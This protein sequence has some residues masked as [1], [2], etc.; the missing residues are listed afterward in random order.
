VAPK[1]NIIACC[2]SGGRKLSIDS[3]IEAEATK[4]PQRRPSL[5]INALS[6]W[7][8]LGVNIVIGFLLTPF[9]I[10]HL[11]KTGYGIWTLVG[12]FIGYYGLL[13]LGVGSAITRYVARYAGQGD[14][15]ALNE[16]ASTAMAM[17]SCTGLLAI[18]ASFLLA[19][20]LAKFFQVAPEHLNGFRYTVWIIGLATGLSFPGNVF[21]SIVRAHERFVA[22]NFA[23][24]AI[25][26]VRAGLVTCLLLSGADLVGVA[27]ATLGSQ[28][29][30]LAVNFLLCRHFTPWVRVRLAFARS[31]FLRKLIAFGG[32][33]TV[34]VV[35]DIMRINLDRC[36]I[37]KMVG[38][39][40]VGVYG[41]AALIIRYM[42]Q[43]IATGMG[44]LTP[45][46]AALDGA[47][48]HAKLQGL[49][50][51]SLSVSALLAF[52][53]SM[54]AIIFGGRFITWWVG[55][56][57]AGAI[58]VLWI[59]ATAYAFALSQNPAIGLMYALK[60]HHYYAIATVIEAVA[61]VVLSILLA[62]KYGIIGV[63][64]GTM[65]PMLIVK[66]LVMPVYV[67][68]IAGIAIWQ[69]VKRIIVPLIIGTVIVVTTWYAGI[70]TTCM[71]FTVAKSIALA[72]IIGLVFVGGV[73]LVSKYT[74]LGGLT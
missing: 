14:E 15:K 60:K 59:I 73:A 40:D 66:I 41:I 5:K 62:P 74:G 57:F 18:A 1:A 35:A 64:L 11:G 67:S 25:T 58:P 21:G 12:S 65:I 10:R 33:T 72:T 22:A 52:G 50:L 29:L 6:N 46:F 38:M 70:V 49:F 56:E 44:V 26:L 19:S 47:N 4:S 17:F 30:G 34:I 20:P 8:A 32:V 2:A 9:I 24:V 27:F 61:N 23:S 39:S 53:A 37:G 3:K 45:R 42:T 16:T 36:V 63:A 13:N 68:R 51:R 69:Y 43:L 31:R 55:K 28:L 54:L 48:E 7:A 71:E